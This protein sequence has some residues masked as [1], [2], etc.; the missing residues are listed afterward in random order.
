MHAIY[1]RG[2]E[3]YSHKN[4]GIVGKTRECRRVQIMSLETRSRIEDPTLLGPTHL[5]FAIRDL[6]PA[7]QKLAI[8]QAREL[9]DISDQQTEILIRELGLAHE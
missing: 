6:S 2:G 5:L 3:I 8:L 1:L 4:P 9:G 7:A